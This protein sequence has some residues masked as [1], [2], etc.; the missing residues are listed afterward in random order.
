MPC[1]RRRRKVVPMS[2]ELNYITE[3]SEHNPGDFKEGWFI[4]A[5][6]LKL[7]VYTARPQGKVR[8]VVIMHH[9]IRAH[10][11]FECLISESKGDR[12]KTYKGSIAELYVTDG[13]AFYTY[14]C[15][16]HGLSESTAEVAFF[17]NTWDLVAD[18]LQ[19]S[20]LVRNENQHLP[21]FLCGMSMGGGICVGA[22]IRSGNELQG[23]ILGAPM[24]SVSQI[25]KKGLNP[26]LVPTAPCLL[27]CMPCVRHMR[28]VAMAK[29]PDPLDRKTAEDDP[30]FESKSHMLVGPAFASMIFCEEIVKRLQEV[31]LPLL[32]IHAKNDTFVDYE[33]SEFLVDRARSTDK[34]LV[35]APEGAGHGVFHEDICREISRNAVRDWLKARVQTE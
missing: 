23:L 25:K 3:V 6:G 32:S 34:K 22:A 2:E 13:F 7:H 11:L 21:I 15:E 24:I 16:G 9:G 14:D 12:R 26:C 33:S 27:R 20:Q 28:I 30:L 4:N 29:N 10:A 8:G 18:L 17:E 5:K 1:C 31:S 19:F 35:V